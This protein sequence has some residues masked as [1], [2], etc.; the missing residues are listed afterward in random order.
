MKRW[1]KLIDWWLLTPALV[2]SL[3]S[4]LLLFTLSGERQLGVYQAVYLILGLILFLV[5]ARLHYLS[6]LAIWPY[7]YVGA[8]VLLALVLVLG[9]TKFGS[10]RWIRLGFFN[11]QPSELGKFL[12]LPAWVSFLWAKK[13]FRGREFVQYLFLVL[14]PVILIAK[15]PDLGTAVLYFVV[16]LA[17]YFFSG[18]KRLYLYIFALILALSLPLLFNFA[19]K[20]YQKERLLVFLYPQ[21]DILGAGYNVWQSMIA[22]G[23]GGWFGKGLGKGTQSQL[24]FLPIRYADFIYATAGEATGFVGTLVIL[25]LYFGLLV[26]LFYIAFQAEEQGYLLALGV[27]LFFFLQVVVNIGMNL[28]IM[29]ITGLPLVFLSYGGS[30]L[31][32]SYILL[33][34]VNNIARR[35]KKELA[36]V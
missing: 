10:A 31:L 35:G 30:S 25:G 23:S 16:G 4:V 34:I 14:L 20:P 9:E 5:F 22:V 12:V 33:G 11:F 18:K 6:L 26:R 8:L 27:G 13:D 36:F 32:T 19:L 21:K 7:L 15:E 17:L 3:L 29:P 28:G 24:R 1:L 2:L